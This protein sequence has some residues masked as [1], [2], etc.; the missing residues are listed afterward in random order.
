MVVGIVQDHAQQVIGHRHDRGAGRRT[1]E[2]ADQRRHQVHGDAADVVQMGDTRELVVVRLHLHHLRH[3]DAVGGAQPGL[4]VAG[5]HLAGAG[6]RHGHV[7][8]MH[9]GPSR[10]PHRLARDAGI[11]ARAEDLQRRAGDDFLAQVGG[12]RAGAQAVHQRLLRAGEQDQRMVA[13]GTR[14]AG[15]AGM[16]DRPRGGILDAAMAHDHGILARAE[17]DLVAHLRQDVEHL[18]AGEADAPLGGLAIRAE[19]EE[20]LQT[21]FPNPIRHVVIGRAQDVG[22][23]LDALFPD[24][25]LDPLG[26]LQIELALRHVRSGLGPLGDFE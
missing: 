6:Q 15:G 4:R 19:F 20:E 1:A 23:V 25:F 7:V 11:A 26:H 13:V 17:G 9:A 12:H 8:D 14:Q 16:H 3:E 5:C 21:G 18:G 22:I 2:A 24:Q 10:H